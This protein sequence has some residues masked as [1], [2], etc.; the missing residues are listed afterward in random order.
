MSDDGP[1]SEA[2]Q[3]TDP[4]YLAWR[5]IRERSVIDFVNAIAGKF[6]ALYSRQLR[7][8]LYGAVF[9]NG[10]EPARWAG[11]TYTGLMLLDLYR[12]AMREGPNAPIS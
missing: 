1:S 10:D 6:G 8:Q 9:S 11:V 4:A 7:D 2:V 12:T 5:E 3:R